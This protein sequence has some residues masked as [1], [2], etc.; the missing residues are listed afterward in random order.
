MMR[1][2]AEGARAKGSHGG[3]EA[4]RAEACMLQGMHATVSSS[5]ARVWARVVRQTTA[6]GLPHLPCRHAPPIARHALPLP[7]H[8]ISVRLVFGARAR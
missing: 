2:E 8:S 7:R 6:Y 5:R 4:P 1:P 3:R